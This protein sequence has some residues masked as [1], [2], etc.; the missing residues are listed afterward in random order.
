MPTDFVVHPYESER[1]QYF[2]KDLTSTYSKT[3]PH[4]RQQTLGMMC[5]DYAF[6]MTLA[7]HCLKLIDYFASVDK[8][9]GIPIRDDVL[10]AGIILL[11]AASRDCS[12]YFWL[13][14]EHWQYSVVSKVCLAEK[15][16]SY[17]EHIGT[18]LHGERDDDRNVYRD[19]LKA[20][21]DL[22][23]S[24]VDSYENALRLQEDVIEHGGS[25]A[26][27]LQRRG[28][29]DAALRVIELTIEAA[30]SVKANKPDEDI[31]YQRYLEVLERSRGV[32]AEGRSLTSTET[33]RFV[34]DYNN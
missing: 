17:V 25:L 9:N 30:K 3:S 20:Y 10:Q 18:L 11:S 23:E 12:E 31:E 33:P 14:T 19:I 26:K 6:E 34:I 8:V 16:E 15:Y 28:Y 29:G 5:N 13:R 22:K 21:M 4:R 27:R 24:S 7:E 32:L 2:V 1:L